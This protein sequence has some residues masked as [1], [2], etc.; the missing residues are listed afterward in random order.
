[1]KKYILIFS[2]MISIACLAQ[3][4]N[5]SKDG[6]QKESF[7]SQFDTYFEDVELNEAGIIQ[8]QAKESFA[9]LPI[10]KKNT[11]MELVLSKENDVLVTVAYRYKRELWEKNKLSNTV[12]LLD[13]WDLNILYKPKTT[14]KTL[15]KTDIHPWF[16]YFGMNSSFTSDG[17]AGSLYLSSRLGFFL[18]KNRWDLALSYSLG[19]SGAGESTTANSDLGLMSKVYFPIEKYNISPYAGLGISYL[20]SLYDEVYNEI[21]NK[22]E[23]PTSTLWQVPIYLG[24][25]WYVGPGSLD[26]GFQISKNSVFMIGYTFS[27]SQ[28]M[29]R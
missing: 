21:T 11:I 3:S 24:V 27:P 7:L 5:E 1:M 25:N 10:E 2:L 16:L 8:L 9:S 29:K 15:Q 4:G 26:F 13:S 12:A 19:M 22:H 6:F 18:L 14:L 28:L 20:W 23:Y 17:D